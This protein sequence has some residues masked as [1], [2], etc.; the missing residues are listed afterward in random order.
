MQMKINFLCKD[1]ILAAPLVIEIARCLDLAKQR[2]HGG[3]LEEL[4]V[5]FKAPQ[6]TNGAEPEHAWPEQERRFRDWLDGGTNRAEQSLKAA[7]AS[8]ADVG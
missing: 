3:V 4:G 2:G 5:F 7:A 6:M 1:S 8:L